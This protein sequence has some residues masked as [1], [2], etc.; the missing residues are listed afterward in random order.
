[1]D[2][3]L[4]VVALGT[5]S[6]RGAAGSGRGWHGAITADRR[7]TKPNGGASVNAATRCGC[8]VAATNASRF[9]G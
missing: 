1:M 9:W 6:G 4:S 8:I 3:G 2:I 7:A 5:T